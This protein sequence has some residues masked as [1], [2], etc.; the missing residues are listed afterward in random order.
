MDTV[1]ID[2]DK[3]IA[4]RTA[5]SGKKVPKFI[6]NY[7]KRLVHQDE[8]NEILLDGKDLTGAAFID[9]ALRMMNIRYE[10]HDAGNIDLDGRYVIVSNHPLGG[11]D[12]LILI[13]YFSKTFPDRGLKVLTNDF[14]MNLKPIKDIF[15]PINKFGMV[16][17]DAAREIYEL[18]ASEKEVLTFPAG[19]CSRKVKGK[20]TDL[21]WKKSSVKKAVESG[22]D[23]L[24]VFF[25]GQNSNHF[26]DVEILRKFLGIKFNIGMALLPGEMFKKRNSSMDFYIRKPIPVE[27][28]T[29]DHTY[30]EWTEYVRNIVYNG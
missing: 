16:R 18:F 12:G 9:N 14:L 19:L 28:F 4:D 17:Q 11:L 15:V 2:L 13:S 24:P 1:Q 10:V 3:I 26:Y 27:T 30:Q 21:E 22:R 29:K 6:V 23:V 25:A 8:I 7:L 5:K 20:I